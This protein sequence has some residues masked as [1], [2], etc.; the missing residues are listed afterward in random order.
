M[1]ASGDDPRFFVIP[2]ATN[3]LRAIHESSRNFRS[4]GALQW[5]VE[6][7]LSLRN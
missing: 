5:R 1:C 2:G 3:L 7:S 6:S 4:K